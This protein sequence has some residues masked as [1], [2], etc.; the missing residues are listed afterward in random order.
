MQEHGNEKFSGPGNTRE[1]TG[2][3]PLG[4]PC[5]PLAPFDGGWS[6]W[7][8]Q[9]TASHRQHLDLQHPLPSGS[10]SPS[11]VPRVWVQ[12]TR[13]KHSKIFWSGSAFN[14][15]TFLPSRL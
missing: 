2:Y 14:L 10:V 11:A 7:A 13:S 4:E 9:R 1:A 12:S 5:V 6:W 8:T 3:P 15:Q